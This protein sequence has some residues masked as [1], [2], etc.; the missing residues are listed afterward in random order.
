MFVY[1]FPYAFLYFPGG[2]RERP[3]SVYE[4]Q[5]NGP[6]QKCLQLSSQPVT[7]QRSQ[8]VSIGQATVINLVSNNKNSS[9]SSNNSTDHGSVPPPLPPRPAGGLG[10]SR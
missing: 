6:V 5:F 4:K 3:Q 10:A 9:S 1:D 2:S 7:Q 8:Q